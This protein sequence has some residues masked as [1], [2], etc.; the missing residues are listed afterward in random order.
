M[1]A[2]AV[3]RA[4]VTTAVSGAPSLTHCTLQPNSSAK[5]AQ[6]LMGSCVDVFHVQK[7]ATAIYV[8]DHED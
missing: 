8:M 2:A 4:C 5:I 6:T 3:G 7:I 1:L